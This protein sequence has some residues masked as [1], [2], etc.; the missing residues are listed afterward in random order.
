[1]PKCSTCRKADAL[2][3]RWERV[4]YWFFSR[5]H[6]DIL[7]LGSQKYT[8]GFADGY[9]EGYRIAL[10]GYPQMLE[11]KAKTEEAE[12]LLKKAKKAGYVSSTPTENS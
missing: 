4:R 12:K 5:F 11:I 8:Q 9:K 6:Q 2:D 1:M 3:T 7:D 10:A